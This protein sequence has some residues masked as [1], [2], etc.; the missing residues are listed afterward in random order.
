MEA[1]E[2]AGLVFA[3]DPTSAD[4]SCIGGNVAMNAGGKKAVLWGTALDNLVSWRMVTPDAR[5]ARGHADATTTSARSTTRR[6]R[7]SSCAWYGAD[8]T[9]VARRE[10][11]AIPGAAFRKAGLGKDVTDKFLA[12][13]PGVQ[14]EGCDGLITSRALRPAPDAAGDPH[15]VPRVLRAGARFDAGDR[16]DQALP[17]RAARR[18]DPRRPRAPRRALREGGRLRDQGEAPRA[19]EDGAARRHRRRRRRRGRE[20]RLR[21]GPHRQRAR[22]RGLRRGVGARRARS[23][24]STARARRRSPGTPTRS[25]STRTSSSRSTASATTPTASSASTSSSRSRTSSSS[26][27]RSRAFFAGPALA[28]AWGPS[29]DARPG[30]GG[31]SPRR[32]TRRA[33]SS[34]PSR[35]RWQDLLA[36][37]DATFPVAAGPLGRRVVEDASCKAPLE[38]IF[39]RPALRA[40]DGALRRDPPRGRCAA[41][42]SSRCTCTPA[43]ATCT[44][45]S[46]STPTTTRCCSRPTPRSRGSWRS[47]A[48]LGGVISGEHGIGITKLEYLTTDEL[49]PFAALQGDESIPTGASTR[50]AAVAARDLANAYTPSFSLIGHESLILEASDIGDDRRL[51]QGLPALR[52]VQAGVRDARAAREPPLL[53]AQQD[54]RHVAADRGVPVRGADA[55][56]RVASATSTSSRD[57]ADHCTVC[58]KC[59]TPC[60]VDIDF[61]DVSIAMRNLLRA[62][63]RAQFRSRHRG[64]DVLPQRD[65]SRD[66]QARAS[67]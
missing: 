27:T 57:V 33:R 49:A 25:R 61:G 3:V 32:S 64:G 66:D 22:R 43:T 6:S 44:R 14:K 59:A 9:T 2:A 39:A 55:A 30:A 8:G 56:R 58:H 10:T 50:Q 26:A 7:R 40:G 62:E 51:D 54:P 63:G 23:S 4:A 36:R 20:G 60:P 13:L 28:H 19:A 1:A 5:V 24:G 46:R 17:R 15:R 29:D 67:A 16:R 48:R 41:A 21:S 53:A 31:R 12:G 11:L 18:R 37:I 45:T 52:Q 47:R 38:E 35:A 42:C 34:P 65:R